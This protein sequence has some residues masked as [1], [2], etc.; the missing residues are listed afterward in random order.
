MHE[1]FYSFFWLGILH[2]ARLP[3]REMMLDSLQDAV[4]PRPTQVEERTYLGV[5]QMKTIDGI[6]P[7]LQDL[8]TFQCSALGCV[9]LTEPAMSILSDSNTSTLRKEWAGVNYLC[10]SCLRT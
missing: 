7:P 6:S 9:T 5:V 8:T 3:S 10:I 1:A 2:A 4:P